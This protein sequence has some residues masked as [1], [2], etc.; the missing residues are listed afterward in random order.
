[1]RNDHDCIK[2]KRG[3][4]FLFNSPLPASGSSKYIIYRV[5]FIMRAGGTVGRGCQQAFTQRME[6]VC[7]ILWDPS[8][9]VDSS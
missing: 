4:A 6:F 1:M 3:P 2:H 8:G 5:L 7:L 9:G